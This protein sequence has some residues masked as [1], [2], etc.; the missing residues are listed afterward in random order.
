MTHAETLTPGL[1]SRNLAQTVRIAAQQCGLDLTWAEEPR[2]PR[3]SFGV[4][5][6]EHKT[7]G[8]H[9]NL[10]AR[11][12]APQGRRGGLSRATGPLGQEKGVG[13]PRREDVAG[14]TEARVLG[15]VPQK[16][17][18]LLLQVSA[19]TTTA[20]GGHHDASGA[21]VHVVGCYLEPWAGRKKQ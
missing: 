4:T 16:L 19:P 3:D 18:T 17:L 9:G 5:R 14:L 10:P 7:H 1:S 13:L 12:A 21:G 6:G 15:E 20:P 8:L 2:W 11:E